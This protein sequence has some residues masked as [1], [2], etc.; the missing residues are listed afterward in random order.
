MSKT[1][2]SLSYKDERTEE[3]LFNSCLQTVLPMGRQDIRCVCTVE[4]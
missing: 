1:S 4:F 2:H 3:Y